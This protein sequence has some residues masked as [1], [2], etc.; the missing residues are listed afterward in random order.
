MRGSYCCLVE[1][2][3][4]DSVKYYESRDVYAIYKYLSEHGSK[5]CTNCLGI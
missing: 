2:H 3:K 4:T 5:V 1:K